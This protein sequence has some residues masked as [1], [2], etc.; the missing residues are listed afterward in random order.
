MARSW[1]VG[2]TIG[3][4]WDP[5]GHACGRGGAAGRHVLFADSSGN[6]RSR[7]GD[8]A[9]YTL[10]CLTGDP[11]A[12]GALSTA[13]YGLKLGLVPDMD[14]R[15][16]ELH[17]ARITHRRRGYPLRPRTEARRLAVFGAIARIICESD[18]TLFGVAVDNRRA[19]GEFGPNANVMDAAWTLVLERFELFV[20]DLGTGGLGH[21]IADRT[22]AADM[23]RIRAL[24]SSSAR[25]HNPISGVRTS[26]IA[27]IEFVDSLE[28]LLVQAADIA[29]YII[30]RH[31]NGDRRFAGM[32]GRLLGRMWVSEDGRQR[33]WKAVWG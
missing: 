5:T 22:G 18:A 14:P 10:G 7:A 32:A 15:S 26:R 28:S 21:V 13:M 19:Y 33:G 9:Y 8:D 23:R 29:A 12:L 16:W 17:G 11:G 30:S 24:V 27:G 2:R 4:A 20:R 1:V 25:R 31:I 6:P 3:P